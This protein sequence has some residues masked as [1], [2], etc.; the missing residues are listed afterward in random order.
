MR[1][2]MKKKIVSS[3]LII[4]FV[5]LLSFSG[6]EGD[7]EEEPG[8]TIVCIGDDFTVGYDHVFNMAL[9]NHSYPIYLA[10]KVNIPVINSGRA[11]ETSA[12]A[13]TRVKNDIISKDPRIVIIMYGLNDIT[14]QIFAATTE[15]NLR[16]MIKKINNGNRKIYLVKFYTDEIGLAIGS[17]LAWFLGE[18]Y[19]LGLIAEYN[20]MFAS[21]SSI[22][23]VTL[24]ENM[25]DG[26]WGV[27]ANM[28]GNM[29]PN[30]NGYKTMADNFFKV[31]E[32]Y[33]KS[34]GLIK[35]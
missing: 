4:G 9:M 2:I 33:L 15:N 10:E 13:L 7:S 26:V 23:N 29:Y 8:T 14:S 18:E 22:K 20:A 25:W 34:N 21:L 16:E 17:Q 11:K 28:S 12:Q 27:S 6:C 31:M 3:V 32:P 30:Q 19:I 5:I 1:D 24:I 35:K